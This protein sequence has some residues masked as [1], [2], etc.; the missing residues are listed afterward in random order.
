MDSL[1]GQDDIDREEALDNG[2]IEAPPSI[3]NQERRMHVR[4]YNYWVSLLGNRALPSIEDLNPEELEDFGANSVLLDFSMGMENPAIIYLGSALREECGITE[5]VERVD[6]V[7]NRSLLTRLTDHY[8]QIIANAAPVGF[9]AEFTN[10]RGAEIMYR[11]ILMPFSSDDETIDFIYGVIS[12]KE[13]ASQNMLD[14]LGEEVMAAMSAAPAASAPAPI[15]AD[16]PSATADFDDED[17]A[18]TAKAPVDIAELEADDFGFEDMSADGPPAE[19]ETSQAPQLQSEPQSE[20]MP[21]TELELDDLIADLIELDS[22]DSLAEV[23]TEAPT[24]SL[25]QG[26]AD[27]VV[28]E[29]AE[30]EAPDAGGDGVMDELDL[31]EFMA[32]DQ[33]HVV[34]DAMDDLPDIDDLLGE[35]GIEEQPEP[36][37]ANAE[38][39]DDIGLDEAGVEAAATDDAL[40]GLDFDI[41]DI[42]L[43]EVGLDEV[44][45]EAGEPEVAADEEDIMSETQD[46]PEAPPLDDITAD[47]EA[48]G[49]DNAIDAGIQSL[50]DMG[51]I[52]L[53]DD[54]DDAEMAGDIAP[55]LAAVSASDD[56][57]DIAG[58]LDPA[59][60]SG[61]LAGALDMARQ[62]AAEALDADARSRTA[63]YRAIGHAYD[64][65]L[66]T[67]QEPAGYAA[68]LEEAGIAVQD[69][70]PMTAVVKLIFGADYDKTRVAE[71]ALALEYALAE[72][73]EKGAFAGQLGFYEGG[74]K[75]LVRDVRAARKAGEP[76]RGVRR[77]ERAYRKIGRA[78]RLD[79]GALTFDEQGIALIVARQEP[80]G[81]VSFVASVDTQ[82]KA[83]Q[84]VLIAA[85]KKI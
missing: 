79:A 56:N 7:P 80:D 25:E 32:A 13:V 58:V 75:G 47:L 39:E 11:G 16:G 68:M 63:L 29:I 34:A 20:L 71:Y 45:D 44:S 22:S 66:V 18:E 21:D 17:E 37:A 41:D 8:L 24:D 50:L 40:S 19:A 42:G 78:Q 38:T 23:A 77:L 15:W 31:S 51:E 83:A 36:A 59:E 54:D 46:E 85:S 84:K 9:E 73:V 28:G 43:D 53:L 10:Q 82:D 2:A 69:R 6:E 72:G 3:G 57:L 12:W 14:E 33:D 49:D 67:Q 30:V 70:S 48:E 26:E 76:P 35:L 4:A 60:T 5:M 55:A 61:G 81:S 27:A 64:F 65:A 62:S 52:G 1:R 74:L